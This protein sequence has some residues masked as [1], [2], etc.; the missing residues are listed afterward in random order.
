MNIVIKIV[1]LF[2][3]ALYANYL[4][5]SLVKKDLTFKLGIC[6]GVLYFIFIPLF[7]MLATGTLLLPLVDFGSTSLS[8]VVL[9]QSH[10]AS[11][12][13]IFFLTTIL[14][15]LY[16]PDIR[17]GIEKRGQAPAD[18]R[19]HWGLP[20]GVYLLLNLIVFIKS[21]LFEGGN[22]YDNRHDF[23]NE[24]GSVAVLAV[25]ALNASKV[26]LS[27]MIL[28]RWVKEN[29]RL[30]LLALLSFLL[31]DMVLSGNRIYVFIAGAIIILNYL[32]KYP[33]TTL[34]YSL[35]SVPILFVAGYFASIFRHMRGPLFEEGMPGFQKFKEVFI[36]S[37]HHE[38]PD[39]YS[40]LSGISESVN[41]NVIYGLF[42]RYNDFL[43]GSTY[44]KTI[45][46]PIPRSVWQN[47]PISITNIT[48]DFFGSVSLVTTF[49]GEMFM[50]FSYYG[51]LILPLVLIFTE[52]G[53]KLLFRQYPGLSGFIMFYMGLMIF[54]MPYSDTILVFLILFFLLRISRF[55]WKVSTD[56]LRASNV[57]SKRKSS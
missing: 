12:T 27:V 44:L 24:G 52:Y 43:Y 15:Y 33:V 21:G 32:R 11:W 31:L 50:N 19:S 8:H 36:Y 9:A 18:V 5:V 30:Y 6:F 45:L 37:I 13:L 35:I 28:S 26:L 22:W 14:F 2:Q 55:R 39:I 42:D 16:F 48:G 56:F 47:K 7:M 54:R 34:K 23:M 38:P 17:S 57:L 40:F 29:N 46:F 53:V 49:I 1:F 25:F 10:R 41:V 3:F 51:I 4:L 20:L